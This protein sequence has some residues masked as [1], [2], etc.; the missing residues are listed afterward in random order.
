MGEFPVCWQN[1]CTMGRYSD[2]RGFSDL[3]R[4]LKEAFKPKGFLLSAAVSPIKEIID[5]GYDVPC[6]AKDLDWISVMTYDYH[7]H[8]DKRTGHVAPL[9]ANSEFDENPY[10]NA[11]S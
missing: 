10:F 5:V 7:G 9:F 4:E 6:I 1:D 2:K 3:V 8:W 11:V